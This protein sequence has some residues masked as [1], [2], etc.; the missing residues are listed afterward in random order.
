MTIQIVTNIDL[1]D[2]LEIRQGKAQVKVDGQTV[3]LTPDKQLESRIVVDRQAAIS[4]GFEFT[5]DGKKMIAD[6]VGRI[7]GTEWYVLGAVRKPVGPSDMDTELPPHDNSPGAGTPER[8]GLFK[9]EPY[10]NEIRVNTTELAKLYGGQIPP[11]VEIWGY[12]SD[13]RHAVVAY[14]DNGTTYRSGDPD[15]G[16]AGTNEYHSYKSHNYIKGFHGQTVKQVP[17]TPE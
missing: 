10:G 8:L 15:G 9:W 2:G 12:N 14:L 7:K 5:V 4:G 1:G 13:G 17:T 6:K 3:A 11:T 16:Y